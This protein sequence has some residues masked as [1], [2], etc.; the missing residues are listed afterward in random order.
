[1]PAAAHKQRPSDS[2]YPYET[3][4]GTRYRFVH[5][6]SAGKQSQRRGFTSPTA[7]RKERERL[8]GRVHRGE[9]RTSRESFA[10]HWDG[11]LARRKP[12]LEHGSWIDYR[13][14]GNKR[15]L[16]EFGPYRLTALTAPMIEGWI[17]ELAPSGIY[18][19][20]TINNALKTFRDLGSVRCP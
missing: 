6:D 17:V 9:V 10:E 3:Q 7:A 19:T 11:W 13:G 18:A 5:R 14:H 20:K 12:Y 15:R 4:A 2:I 16:P 1:M 8:M